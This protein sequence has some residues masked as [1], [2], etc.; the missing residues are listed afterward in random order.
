MCTAPPGTLLRAGLIRVVSWLALPT[1]AGPDDAESILLNLV[2]WMGTVHLTGHR[3]LLIVDSNEQAARLS[4]QLRGRLVRLGR[5]TET[6]VPLGLQGTYAGV[7]DL[8]QA[9]RNAWG[10]AGFEGNRRGP[11]N[12]EQIMATQFP[13]GIVKPGERAEAVADREILAETGVHGV[14]V[15]TLG[16]RQHPTTNVLCDYLLC[17][18]VAGDGTNVDGDENIGV[19]WIDKTLLTRFIPAVRSMVWFWK[20]SRDERS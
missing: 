18:Y 16:A 1:D 13:V 19:A 7:G 11:V 6:G 2:R 3:S 9:R 10:L 20:P 8:V 17:D 5:V 12:R 4:A 15:R 14:V